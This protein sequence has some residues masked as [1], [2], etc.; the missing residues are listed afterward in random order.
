MGFEC[1]LKYITTLIIDRAVGI[2]Q[3]VG[4]PDSSFLLVEGVKRKVDR[5]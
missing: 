5:E 2:C 4:V 1:G 3:D